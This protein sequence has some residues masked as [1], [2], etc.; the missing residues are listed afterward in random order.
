MALAVR[1]IHDAYPA[2]DLA[3]AEDRHLRLIDDD[4]RREQASADAV[5]RDGEGAAAHLL[6]PQPAGT[7]GAHELAEARRELRQT[8]VLRPMDHRHDETLVA[9]RRADA[10]VRVRVKL[11]RVLVERRVQR[12]VRE[13]GTR[14][15]GHEVGGE[16]EADALPLVFGRVTRA[17]R[18]HTSEIRLEHRGHVRRLRETARHVLG[19]AP[20]HGA[21]RNAPGV[22]TPASSASAAAS[23]VAAH[24]RRGVGIVRQREPRAFS[25]RCDVPRPA[26]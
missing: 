16:G 13:Q 8:H 25:D 26:P 5:I 14:A 22:A 18:L 1:R 24:F 15:S 4:G 23:P 20:T 2:F 12:R 21:M 9:E 10:D 7:R 19:H 3:D 17:V 11:E 6:R